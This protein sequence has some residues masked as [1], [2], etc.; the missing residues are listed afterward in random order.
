[1][2]SWHAY[3]RRVRSPALLALYDQAIV[4][5]SNFLTMLF[6]A[7]YLGVTVFGSFALAYTSLLFLNNHHR[8]FLTQ[9]LN[10]IGATEDRDKFAERVG[11]LAMLH[12]GWIPIGL[13]ALTCAGVAFFPDQELIAAAGC[14]FCFWQLQELFRRAWFSTSQIGH[15]FVSDCISYGGQLCLLLALWA[16]DALTAPIA[17]M[18]MGATSALAVVI[19]LFQG[20]PIRRVSLQAIRRVVREHWAFGKWLVYGV[21]AIWGTSQIYPF[22]LQIAG[23]AMMVGA[24]AASRNLLNGVGILVQAINSYMPTK[25]KQV[26][27]HHGPAGLRRYLARNTWPVVAVGGIFCTVI[28]VWAGEILHLVYGQSFVDAASA[29]RILSIGTFAV[30]LTAV[31]TVGLIAL[32]KTRAVFISNLLGSSFTAL[33]G[34]LIVWKYGLVGAASAFSIGTTIVLL[35]QLWSLRLAIHESPT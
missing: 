20:V 33:L 28:A 6:L 18:A 29:L 1:M 16:T 2:T 15:A 34:A 7:R 21:F 11:V 27:A 3:A 30:T 31:P 32:E 25:A 24:F 9:P 17:F 19:A 12:L 35:H 22:L 10:V 26:V 4:S 13:L 8:A 14:Y 5:G 23:G